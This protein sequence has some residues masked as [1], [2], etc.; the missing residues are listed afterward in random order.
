MRTM[1]DNLKIKQTTFA[2]KFTF[3]SR[4]V[5]IEVTALFAMTLPVDELE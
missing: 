5:A 4:V 3:I 2:L 1:G